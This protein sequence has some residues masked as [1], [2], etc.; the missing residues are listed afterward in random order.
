MCVAFVGAQAQGSADGGGG[1]LLQPRLPPKVGCLSAVCPPCASP[2]LLAHTVLTCSRC[3]RHA[4]VRCVVAAPAQVHREVARQAAAIPLPHV[5]RRPER[6]ARLGA[7]ATTAL[8]CTCFRGGGGALARC[9]GAAAAAGSE[10]GGSR[11]KRAAAAGHGGA[12]AGTDAER[13]Y[14]AAAA[15]GGRCGCGASSCCGRAGSGTGSSSRRN[16]AAFGRVCGRGAS[17]CRC[18]WK[19]SGGDAG[20]GGRGGRGEEGGCSSGANNRFD[21][22]PRHNNDFFQLSLV[23]ADAPAGASN[24]QGLHAAEFSALV[25]VELLVGISFAHAIAAGE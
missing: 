16:N 25:G 2:L 15:V 12:F 14:C 18:R 1:A 22:M 11:R 19:L 7:A 24:P 9:G 5:P 13:H 6:R 20:E 8:D 23:V 3:W 17:P 21:L 10:G 4:L